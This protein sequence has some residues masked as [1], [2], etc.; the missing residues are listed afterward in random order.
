ME[1]DRQTIKALSAD[2]RVKILKLLSER[3]RI[4]AEISRQ[5][6]LAPSTVVEHLQKLE[7]SGLVKR[8]ETEH[9]WI[10][11]EITEKGLS[12]I[13]P[14]LPIHII[15]SLSIGVVLT[16]VGLSNIFL[17]EYASMQMVQKVAEISMPQERIIPIQTINWIFVA[18]LLAGLFAVS[19]SLIKLLRK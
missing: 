17:T 6:D 11:Y 5:L 12:L 19:I 8:N 16:F 3:R 9:K 1:I 13:K 10:Y 18:V 15:L 14:T 2:T 7:Q 4:P